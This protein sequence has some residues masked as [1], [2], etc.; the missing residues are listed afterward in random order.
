MR[1]YVGAGEGNRTPHILQPFGQCQSPQHPMSA[2]SS[3]GVG[4]GP[5]AAATRSAV[6]IKRRRVDV[7]ILTT[8]V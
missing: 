6:L 8:R 4:T 1:M 7:R 5:G 3:A 2:E